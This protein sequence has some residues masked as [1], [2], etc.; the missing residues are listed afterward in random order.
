LGNIVSQSISEATAWQNALAQTQAVIASTGGAAGKTADE[1]GFLAEEL[2]AA[3]GMSLFS[4]DAI[5]GAENVLATFTN[6]SGVSFD[7]ATQA[8]LDIS[9]ALGTDLKS[10]SIQVG[11]A[12]ND[13]IN[14][15]SALSRVGVSFTEQQK[16]QIKTLQEAGNIAGA[17][18]VI[19]GELNKEFGG[20]AAAAVNTYAGQMT[21]LTAQLDDVKQGIGEALLPILSKLGNLL[22]AYAVPAVEE[23]AGAFTAFVDSVEWGTVFDGISTGVSGIGNAISSID[24]ASVGATV[25]D[26]AAL[27]FGFLVSIDWAAIGATLSNVGNI[28]YTVL[29]GAFEFLAP[30][31]QRVID[32]TGVLIPQLVAIS[33]GIVAAFQSPAVV[34]AFGYITTVAGQIADIFITLYS[35]YIQD[36]INAVT[37]LAPY[38]QIA[39]DAVVA[40]LNYVMP[41]ISGV[42]TAIQ[43]ALS[44]DTAG[45][46]NTLSTVFSTVWSDIQTAVSTAVDKV[47]GYLGTLKDK[48]INGGKE[49]INGVVK[50]ISDNTNKVKDALIGAVSSA[51]EAVKKFLGIA[52]PSK[53]MAETVG[54]P[55]SQGIAAGIAAG[56]STVTS[57]AEYAG[58]MAAG[59][60]V[61]NYYNLTANYANTQSES[62][63]LSDLRTL[64]AVYGGA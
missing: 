37:Q 8:V 9:Q 30:I 31:V 16:E 7:N 38:F 52:S 19:L 53:L 61:N 56:V 14:G 59:A 35:I 15:V 48:F 1:F 13:P 5:L 11:K 47:S 49:I 4:D 42:L 24:W 60:T 34:S 44:G 40:A 51:W 25:A 12:L 27:F 28:V 32:V 10:A 22:V 17:Q 41:I 45:A 33:A 6:I 23:M 62:N 55:F 18:A 54:I 21:V 58:A 3:S 36:L 50:G 20:S 2:S 64:Q 29:V 57:A 43:Q 46:L 39:F 26:L 63:I